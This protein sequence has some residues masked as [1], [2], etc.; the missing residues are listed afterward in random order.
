MSV[1]LLNSIQTVRNIQT[2]GNVPAGKSGRKLPTIYLLTL[3][4][5]FIW[6]ST[7]FG[8]EYLVTGFHD[9][10]EEVGSAPM[11]MTRDGRMVRSAPTLRS[12]IIAANQST[13]DVVITLEA[14]QYVLDI[15]GAAENNSET[16]DLDINK[17]QGSLTIQGTGTAWFGGTT[18]S[19]DLPGPFIG[20]R[21]LHLVS[22][23]NVIIRDLRIDGGYAWD[24][25]SQV[26]SS[27]GGGILVN[28]GHLTL[29]RV[30]VSS[31]WAVGNP[32]VDGDDPDP[33][34]SGTPGSAGAQGARGSNGLNGA[35]GAPDGGDGGDGANGTGG[36]R[37]GSGG[38][39]MDGHDGE[40]VDARVSA[41]MHAY[42]GGIAITGGVVRL[43]DS[44]IIQNTAQGGQGGRGSSGQDGGGGGAGGSGGQGGL[45]GHGGPGGSGAN[46]WN[47]SPGHG[48][49]GG[50][51]GNGGDGGRG[52]SGGDGGNGGNG[53]DGGWGGDG[54]GG[55]IAVLGGRL[56]IAGLS[57]V[58]SNFAYGG[59]GGNGGRGGRGGTGGIGR[60]GGNG[61]YGGG[62][63]DGGS[64]G[65]RMNTGFG[66]NGGYPGMW[67]QHGMP[68]SGG[69]PGNSGSSGNGGNGGFGGQAY[70]G[71]IYAVADVVVEETG[72]SGLHRIRGSAVGGSGGS[73]GQA[74]QLSASPQAAGRHGKTF[75]YGWSI[76]WQGRGGDGGLG[77]PDDDEANRGYGTNSRDGGSAV[78]IGDDWKTPRPGGQPGRPGHGG[79]GGEGGNV[80]GGA[81]YIAG[82]THQIVDADISGRAEGGPGGGGNGGSSRQHHVVPGEGIGPDGAS[83][84]D[85]GEGGPMAR[86]RN[87]SS[88]KAGDGGD[89][90]EGGPG[91]A[92]GT[93]GHGGDGG[94]GGRGG[95]ARG[96]AVSLQGG[97]YSFERIQFSWGLAEGGW[98]GFTPAGAAGDKGGDGGKGGQGGAGGRGGYAGLYDYLEAGATE[99]KGGQGAIG[100][101]GG[102]GGDGGQG[103]RGGDAPQG[104]DAYGGGIFIGGGQTAFVDCTIK[105]S[106]A[107]AGLPRDGG[108]GGLGG[109][110]GSGGAG[111][112]GGKGGDT[113]GYYDP[114]NKQNYSTSGGTGGTGGVG[115]TGGPGGNNETQG[116][117]S[118]G[119]A[120]GAGGEPGDPEW[121]DCFYCSAPGLG[122]WGE[123]GGAG[124]RGGDAGVGGDGADGSNAYGGGIY[125][126]GGQVIEAG[127]VF[128]GDNFQ[129]VASAASKSSDA[130]GKPGEDGKLDGEARFPRSNLAFGSLQVDIIPEQAMWR[131]QGTD[132]WL[133]SGDRKG[134]LA[135]DTYTVEF[136]I[137]PGWNTQPSMDVTIENEEA[138]EIQV[139]YT[140]NNNEYPV[141]LEEGSE[142]GSVEGSGKYLHNSWVTLRAVAHPGYRFLYW[143]DEH[144]NIY[145]YD[146]VIELRATEGLILKAWFKRA[147]SLSGVLMLLLDDE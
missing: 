109:P 136:S 22:N 43:V 76:P 79:H 51:G 32:G 70:G 85:G 64:G 126:A 71:S 130:S 26:T 4:L 12:A 13:E 92:G 19:M 114:I 40:E 34:Q 105:D 44:K 60:D 36:E 24:D 135:D 100:G 65:S 20:D 80:Q 29:E 141:E 139:D 27:R 146:E 91:G 81:I 108:A 124:G 56:E 120:G 84:I 127:I 144:G 37:G 104:G 35:E 23:T 82:G 86:G 5:V 11:A 115:G 8:T 75:V 73:G 145:S 33:A 14:G 17:P 47:T 55:G 28:A 38:K 66:G 88:L 45:G 15:P 95:L 61:G 30:E 137:V 77:W 10:V 103:G 123:R 118:Q 117:G 140:A 110:G 59:A 121:N 107:R 16:G 112:D 102:R 125:Y 42:G 46:G 72:F 83:E 87:F 49:D 6:G 67:G 31:N 18:I 128:E 1:Q 41:G 111:G 2:G 50:H 138:R 57:E 54:H 101:L 143:K 147:A 58:D 93:G 69:A 48:G 133:N 21:V 98:A 53:T 131:L 78:I 119:G 39:G 9:G 122:G 25:G 52:G 94:S 116:I 113:R 129:A 134:N 7:A 99:G 74:G 96:G 68:G 89:A 106:T 90:W 3:M 63:G 132:Q 97:V 62:A 142:G